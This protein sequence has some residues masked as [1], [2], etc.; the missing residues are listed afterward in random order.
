MIGPDRKEH[1]IA[2]MELYEKIIKPYTADRGVTWEVQITEEDV[3]IKPFYVQRLFLK[4]IVALILED[5]WCDT[6]LC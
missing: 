3:S 5:L 6:A 2:V 1:K 4:R